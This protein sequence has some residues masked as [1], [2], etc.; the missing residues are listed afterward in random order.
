MENKAEIWRVHPEYTGIEVSTFG[1]VRTLDMLISRGNGT[2]SLKGRILKPASDKGGY[3]RVSIPVDGKRVTKSVH[4]LVAQA[5]IQNPNNL[6][7]VN[8]KNCVR[9]DNRVI[10]LE[11]CTRS[12]NQKYREKYGISQTEAQ[13]HPVFAVN[14]TTLKV[15]KYRSQSEASRELGVSISNINNV[16]K[17]KQKKTHGYWFVNDDGNAV[18]VVKSKLHDI[19]KTGLKLTA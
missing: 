14:L 10:N 6:P 2:R 11:F 17:G 1:R 4:R 18:D 13:G 12:Y 9:D 5:F 3:L 7:Q 19:G 16:V 15:S 8:H